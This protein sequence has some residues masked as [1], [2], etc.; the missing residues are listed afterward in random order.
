MTINFQN[1]GKEDDHGYARVSSTF[2]VSVLRKISSQEHLICY[3]E[4][5]NANLPAVVFG[6]GNFAAHRGN[7]QWCIYNCDSHKIG[8]RADVC[9][10]YCQCWPAG[11]KPPAPTIPPT[12]PK[13]T[14]PPTTLAPT[15][16]PAPPTTFGLII[17]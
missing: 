17:D 8:V 5:T 9:D 14:T 16:T 2:Q 6:T 1:C 12:T 13:P 11:T 3:M 7:R 10:N 4:G 15:T